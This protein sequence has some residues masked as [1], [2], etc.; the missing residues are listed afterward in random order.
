MGD[1]K[2]SRKKY[3]TPN[4]PWQGTRIQEENVLVAKYGLKNK[5][6]LWKAQTFLRNFRG[7]ARD[8]LGRQGQGVAQVERE[9]RQLLARLH[10]LG[11][12]SDNA[13][14][15]DVLALNTEAILTRRLQTQAYL[16]GLAGTIEQGRQFIVHRHVTVNGRVVTIPGHLVKRSEEGA[17]AWHADSA[18][19][20]DSH[21]MHPKPRANIVL[22]TPVFQP[23][24][25]FGRG[26]PP[27][28]GPPR[29]RPASPS[30][31]PAAAAPTEATSK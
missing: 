22:E 14:L 30:P 1:P 29:E 20:M 5:T 7:Q 9:T 21:P 12:V 28:R 8:L 6:E 3:E 10:T 17:I 27:R 16:K 11:V 4:H 2:F 31:A 26:G 19:A 23:R 15:D 13:T 18:V 24:D 25:K